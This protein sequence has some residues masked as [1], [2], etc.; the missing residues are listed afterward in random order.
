MLDLFKQKFDAENLFHILKSL[1]FFDDAENDPE[2]ILLE[3]VNWDEV[4]TRIIK[5]VNLILEK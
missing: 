4:K 2:P 3:K 5:E 1:T